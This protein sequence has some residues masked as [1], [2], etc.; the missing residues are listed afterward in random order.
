M[1]TCVCICANERV[2]YWRL[3]HRFVCTIRQCEVPLIDPRPPACHQTVCKRETEATCVG[4]CCLIFSFSDMIHTNTDQFPL[5]PNRLARRRCGCVFFK[6][7]FVFSPLAQKQQSVAAVFS[8]YVH[9]TGFVIEAFLL[10]VL[11]NVTW[12]IFRTSAEE[13]TLIHFSF[14]SG[15][16]M[17]R[18]VARSCWN[19]WWNIKLLGVILRECRPTSLLTC[20]SRCSFCVWLCWTFPFC[21]FS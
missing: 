10:T 3:L 18:P 12:I 11:L 8:E 13:Q 9:S 16:T 19:W 1:H 4:V 5:F 20:D 7:D 17:G 14:R 2:C 6:C 21:L 15:L